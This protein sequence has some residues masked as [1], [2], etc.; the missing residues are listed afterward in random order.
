MLDP[1]KWPLEALFRMVSERSDWKRRHTKKMAVPEV[2]L[3]T[4]W[5]AL[6][7][8][9]A[10]REHYKFGNARQQETR[11]LFK[12]WSRGCG[13]FSVLGSVSGSS[14]GTTARTDVTSYV[15]QGWEDSSDHRRGAVRCRH[16]NV[17]SLLL[18]FTVVLPLCKMA[19]GG[20]LGLMLD[21]F[22]LCKSLLLATYQCIVST[23]T[24]YILLKTPSNIA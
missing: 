20:K 7:S 8:S 16:C 21:K 4:F 23:I 12:L 24:F 22:K 1:R 19:D 5:S 6:A 10:K 9:H 11:L 18:L 3:L 13:C 2:L 17:T 15:P 14:R